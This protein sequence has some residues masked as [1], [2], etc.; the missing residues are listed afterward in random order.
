[1][2]RT[3]AGLNITGE[4]PSPGLAGCLAGCLAAA[5]LAEL[6]A[7]A[8]VVPADTWHAPAAA[9]AVLPPQPWVLPHAPPATEPLTPLTWELYFLPRSDP[10]PL[11]VRLERRGRERG[12]RGGAAPPRR[13]ALRAARPAGTRRRGAC[14]GGAL[15][16]QPAAGAGQGHC[17]GAAGGGGRLHA[18]HPHRRAP[19]QQGGRATAAW[20]CWLCG[21]GRDVCCTACGGAA[22]APGG[23]SPALSL[24][25]LPCPCP[26]PAAPLPPRSPC[27]RHHRGW[28]GGQRADQPG[29]A[30]A[31]GLSR[32]PRPGERVLHQAGTGAG[33]CP[34]AGVGQA[35]LLPGM[36]QAPPEVLTVAAAGVAQKAMCVRWPLPILPTP[37]V[38]CPH[39]H[40][41]LP[42]PSRPPG[43]RPAPGLQGAAASHSG[44]GGAQPVQPAARRRGGRCRQP[45]GAVQLRP[46]RAC[47][48]RR[49]AHPAPH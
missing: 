31:G 14:G 10:R 6:Q 47:W 40:M 32:A 1:M 49:A 37:H 9:H 3:D 25:C 35:Q 15:E 4:W 11:P 7:G 5:T 17:G 24:G 44:G 16:R 19:R 20:G 23:C 43:G 21:C 38:A 8:G 13:L 28:R 45:P 18:A 48:D 42:P 39:T 12:S 36:G 33:P 30:A 34:A 29:A 26:P 46:R 22:D 2:V 27:R 41:P